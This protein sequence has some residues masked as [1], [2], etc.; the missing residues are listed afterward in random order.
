[1]D[2]LGI[3]HSD[4]TDEAFWEAIARHPL[5]G[6][7]GDTPHSVCATYDGITMAENKN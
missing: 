6:S 4:K 3:T 1:V 7:G 5:R 2:R